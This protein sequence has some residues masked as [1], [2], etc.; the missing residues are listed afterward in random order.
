MH[1]FYGSSAPSGE[2][3]VFLEEES[4]LN[5]R[6]HS[7]YTFT[8]SSDDVRS[9]GML[10]LIK[11]G[12]SVPWNPF[13][14]NEVRRVVERVKPDVVHVHNSFPLL[15]PSIFHAI[16]S[17][18]ATVLTL[19]NYR[20][21]CPAAIPVRNGLICL[22]CI[23]K[24]SAVPAVVHGC[25]RNSRLATLP[26]AISVDLHRALSTWRKKI[27]A[28]IV[29]SNFQ[30]ELMSSG[31][32]PREKLHIKPNFYAG[33]PIVESWSKRSEYALF[34]GRLSEEKGVR[35]LLNAWRMWGR[36]APEL[37]IIGDGPLRD[38][39]EALS[40][41]LPVKFLGQVP[42]VRAQEQIAS[43]RLLI[44]PSQCFEG[45]PMVLVEAF[46][47]GTPVA[48]SNIGPL[49]SIVV[50]DVTGVVFEAN[51][52]GSLL[53]QVKNVFGNP[54]KLEGLAAEARVAFERL[55]TEDENYKLLLKIYDRA[56]ENNKRHL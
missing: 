13:S 27:D 2:N 34:V 10:G 9:K 31:G 54:T 8:R 18:A 44:L 49:P 12:A 39:L 35:T 22:D 42:P 21:L 38:E 47:F 41:G 46:A 37:R 14:A 48:V 1:N 3:M 30:K 40:Q 28:F 45:F 20:V 55:Y 5:R 6:G 29:F 17:K 19:H 23:T 56:I 16:G 15:S 26:L 4:L 11:G 33:D 51:H 7:V 53:S 43:G 50:N 25:Y 32:L 36:G 52:P 24:K